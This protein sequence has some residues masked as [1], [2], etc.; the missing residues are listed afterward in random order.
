MKK[1]I[2]I[3]CILKDFLPLAVGRKVLQTAR[4]YKIFNIQF[5]NKNNNAYLNLTFIYLEQQHPKL[6]NN[7]KKTIKK[8]NIS[9]FPEQQPLKSPPLLQ[10]H[11]HPLNPSFIKTFLSK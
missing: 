11:P 6:V 4:G 1:S 5:N 8:N 9:L 3:D 2:N 7:N 10:P